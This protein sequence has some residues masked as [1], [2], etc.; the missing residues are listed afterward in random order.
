MAITLWLINKLAG[1]SPSFYAEEWNHDAV[2]IA[3]SINVMPVMGS[4]WHHIFDIR[5]GD[6]EEIFVI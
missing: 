2:K 4:Q 1:E 6:T 5:A 3:T